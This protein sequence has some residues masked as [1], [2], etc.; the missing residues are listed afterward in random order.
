MQAGLVFRR[1]TRIYRI[2]V[3]DI[4]KLYVLYCCFLFFFSELRTINGRFI[5]CK[6]L[7]PFQLFTAHCVEKK[8]MLFF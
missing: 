8:Q 6:Q 2:I 7:T 4:I 5:S 3:F 1:A